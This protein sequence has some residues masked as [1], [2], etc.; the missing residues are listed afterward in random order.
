M[1]EDFGP[2]EGFRLDVPSICLDSCYCKLCLSFVEEEEALFSIFRKIDDP[3]VSQ[4]P[5][6]RSDQTL[7]NEHPKRFWV[8]LAILA[9]QPKDDRSNV[10][11]KASSEAF[12]LVESCSASYEEGR[13]RRD[14][15]LYPPLP[16]FQAPL[17]T[18]LEVQGPVDYS[19]GGEDY[20]LSNLKVCEAQLQFLSAVPAGYKDGQSW[21]DAACENSKKHSDDYHLSPCMDES[22]A[23]GYQPKAKSDSGKEDPGSKQTNSQRSWE[24]KASGGDGVDQDGNRKAVA[25]VKP[26]ISEHTSDR[27]TRNDV[28]VQ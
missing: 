15:Q 18:N 27:G 11:S 2:S 4:D 19:P 17:S 26:Q 3:P 1:P 14:S 6:H 28:I 5:N 8:S 24:L 20:H 16:T 23:D 10:Q 7:D 13:T 9:K 25:L 22:R 12:Q 21:V